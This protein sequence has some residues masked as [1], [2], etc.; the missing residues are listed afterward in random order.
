MENKGSKKKRVI[1]YGT[2]DLFHEGHLNILK[3][4]KQY[5]DYLIVGVTSESYDRSR[6]KLNVKQSLA[7]RIENVRETGLADL[8]IVEEYEGQKI[9]D[10]Q[11]YDIDTFVIGSDWVG[12][13]D[14]L[15]EYCKVVYLERTKGISSTQ[16]R[17]KEFG[18]VKLGIVGCGRIARRFLPE[19]KF[20]SGLEVIGAFDVDRKRADEFVSSFEIMNSYSSYEDMLKEVNAVYIATPHVYH[21]DYAKD[22]LLNSKHVLCEK[23]LTLDS[24]SAAT[25]FQ[26]A[27]EKNCV[28][29]EAIKTAYCPGFQKLVALSKAKT[30]GDIKCLE[31]TFTKLV[32]D[33]NSREYDKSIGGGSLYELGS[34]PL[35]AAIKIL[36]CEPKNTLIFSSKDKDKDID[37]FTT[38]I[39]VY[40]SAIAILKVGIGAKSEGNMIISGTSGYIYVPAPWW[41]TEYFEVRSENPLAKKAYYEKFDGEGLRYEIAEFVSM[42]TSNRI[43]SYK[44][45]PEE[46]VCISGV[47][48]KLKS[49]EALNYAF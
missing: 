3:R 17:E 48:E 15:S 9:D 22:A 7:E 31:A 27:E 2:F 43:K 16:L 24:A 28:L 5:G 42:I 11:K 23:P 18:I 10:I 46:S 37:L 13:F 4:A 29:L 49:D 12:K 21:F 26:L 36:G 41:K 34:Y 30:V 14:Y 38:V 33:K 1:T 39:L 35:M 44:L 6:G 32:D 19:S 8:I 40:S 20:V 45:K 47:L 25:L